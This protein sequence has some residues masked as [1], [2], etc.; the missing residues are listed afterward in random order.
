[1]LKEAEPPLITD[2]YSN[3]IVKTVMR[4]DDCAKRCD[5]DSSCSAFEFGNGKDLSKKGDCHLRSVS[6]SKF[7]AQSGVDL[8]INKIF[9]Y[10]W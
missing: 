5:E 9:I 4:V 7:T 8:Y 10:K 2:D 1:L 6:K 3:R